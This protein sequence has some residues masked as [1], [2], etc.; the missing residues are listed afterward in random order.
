MLEGI[1]F[2]FLTPEE[3]VACN[4]LDSAEIVIAVEAERNRIVGM[5]TQDITKRGQFCDS[6]TQTC[7]VGYVVWTHV[8]MRN[9]GILTTMVDWTCERLGTDRSR[10]Y[11][12]PRETL[13]PDEAAFIWARQ[14]RLPPGFQWTEGARTID[15][16][17]KT[18]AWVARISQA[19]GYEVE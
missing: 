4:Y 8:D 7:A 16:V 9:Q 6:C 12:D 11:I 1:E 18:E 13:S 5:L 14:L 19:L 3:K 10:L 15:N 2:R 17:R